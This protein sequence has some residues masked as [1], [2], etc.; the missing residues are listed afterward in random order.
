MR[1]LRSLPLA[2][3]VVIN[4]CATTVEEYAGRVAPLTDGQL[5]QELQSTDLRLAEL[6]VSRQYL[7][8][9]RPAPAYTLTGTTFY[10]G[11]FWLQGNTGTFNFQGHSVYRLTPDYSAQFG[12][13]VAG[14]IVAVK[15]KNALRYRA[16][17]ISEI[18]TRVARHEAASQTTVENFYTVHPELRGH[19]GTVASLAPWVQRTHSEMPTDQ[20]LD[21]IARQARV[22]VSGT[23]DSYAGDWYGLIV[24]EITYANGSK[25]PFWMYAKL[26]VAQSGQGLLGVGELFD[27]EQVALS[28]I[29]EKDGKVAGQVVNTTYNL[30]FEI[31]G[32]V[33]A[34]SMVAD[35]SG[36][37]GGA[38]AVG[39]A[40]LV[41]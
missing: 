24:E 11:A 3:V 13:A 28:A 25:T 4:A 7:L 19:E 18:L 9:T 40:I 6:G 5:V 26:R 27:G 14:M 8:T 31:V 22:V 41:R 16:A 29:V 15:T 21:E 36:E 12:Y 1:V 37:S 30:Q 2:S 39:R 20:L 35:F 17:L 34:S 10:T 38:R 32:Q 23:R 33:S